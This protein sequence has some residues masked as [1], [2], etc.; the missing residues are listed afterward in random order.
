M[1]REVEVWADWAELGGAV[2]MGSLRAVEA[3]ARRS[4]LSNTTAP[5]WSGVAR[6]GSIPIW[7]WWT[8]RNISMGKLARISAFSS[9]PRR[10]VGAGS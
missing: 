8:G 3:R 10:I 5:G 9:I 7:D 6:S 1:S 4:F 2:R